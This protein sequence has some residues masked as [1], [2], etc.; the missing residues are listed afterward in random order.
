LSRRGRKADKHAQLAEAGMP[1]L[2]RFFIVVALICGLVYAGMVA[3]V[4][5]V[6]PEQREIVQT[7]PPWRLNKDK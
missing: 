5:Y 7:V 3:L 1:T 4:T 6:H 2:F